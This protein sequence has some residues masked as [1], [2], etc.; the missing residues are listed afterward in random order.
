MFTVVLLAIVKAGNNRSDHQLENEQ[1]KFRAMV[2][3][4]PPGK[5]ETSELQTAL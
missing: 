3:Y 4:C 5:M 2:E 1:I